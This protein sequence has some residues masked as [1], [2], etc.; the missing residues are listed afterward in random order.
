[1]WDDETGLCAQHIDTILG[2][3]VNTLG[4]AYV[5]VER[6]RERNFTLISYTLCISTLIFET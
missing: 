5:M 6:E 1:M 2:S 3:I 4:R